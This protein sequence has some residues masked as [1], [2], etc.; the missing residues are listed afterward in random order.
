[1][2][3][4]NNLAGKP[5]EKKGV[6]FILT[7]VFVCIFLAIFSIAFLFF[8]DKV[9]LNAYVGSRKTIEVPYVSGLK[10]EDSIEMLKEKN[11]KWQIMGSGAYVIKSEPPGGILV[12]EGRIVKLY[13]SDNPR[14]NT[15]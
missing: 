2:K 12:K 5:I 14:I 10:V 15:P 3:K 7:F 8:A 1:M 4:S 9:V 6:R 13:L 11:L